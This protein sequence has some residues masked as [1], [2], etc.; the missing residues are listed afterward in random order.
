MLLFWCVVV[1]CVVDQSFPPPI[2][3]NYTR[4]QR[5]YKQFRWRRVALEIYYLGGGSEVRILSKWVIVHARGVSFDAKM[6]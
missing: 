5:S 2:S 4:G 6:Y 3:V 1:W